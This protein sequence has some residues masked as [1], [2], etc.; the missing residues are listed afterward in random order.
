MRIEMEWAV[1]FG[2]LPCGQWA[3]PEYEPL[4]YPVIEGFDA[5]V[6]EGSSEKIRASE[7][8][9]DPVAC[10]RSLYQKTSRFQIEFLR[11]TFTLHY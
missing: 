3:A 2:V 6:L 4:N 5:E 7:Y 8:F 1:S 11:C 10:D 9:A